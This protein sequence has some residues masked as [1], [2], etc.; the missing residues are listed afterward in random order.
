MRIV[1]LGTPA[2][3][4]PPL[5]ALVAAGH[6]VAL[7][8]TQPDRRRGRGGA[9]VP[10]AVKAA[11]LELGLPVRTPERAGEVLDEVAASGATVGVVVAFG[12]L[13]RQSL[14][15]ALPYGFLNVHFSLLPRWRGAAPVERALLAGDRETGV[16][17]MRIDAG[18]DTGPVYA[19]E[20]TPI[21]PDETAGELRARLV[22][23]GTR[24][25]VETLPLVPELEPVEQSGE[26]VYADKL[27]VEEFRLD[28]ARPAAEL[29]RVVR[30]GNPRPGAWTV[31][32]GHRV[33][34]LRA[35]ARP[36]GDDGPATT[37]TLDRRARLRTGDGILVIDEVQPEGRRAMAADAWLRGLHGD[38]WTVGA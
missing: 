21:A 5:R 27:A 26:P 34:V 20:A 13:L 35:H 9:S 11:A 37:G 23:I 24:L 18:L 30:A 3:A 32:G 19:C 25:L 14:L 36:P 1:F 6:D 2:D 15:D 33:K 4:V 10:S 22:D 31:V 38:A 16:C 29:A 12:Q 17:L 8:V 28:P 7:V